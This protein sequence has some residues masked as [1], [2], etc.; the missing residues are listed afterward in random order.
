MRA[1]SIRTKLILAVA[2][3]VVLVMTIMIAYSGARF[4]RALLTSAKEYAIADAKAT[5]ARMD[6]VLVSGMQIARDLAGV[7]KG[8]RDFPAGSRRAILSGFARSATDSNKSIL[9]AWYIFEPNAVDGQDA[10]WAGKPGHTTKGQFVPYWFRNVGK[11]ELDFATEDVEGTVTSFYTVPHDTRKEYMTD[12]YQFDLATG[13]KVTAISFCVPIIVNDELVGVA[14]VD[15]G[16]DE[17]RA[18][19]ASGSS[20]GYAFILANDGTFIA[21]PSFDMVGSTFAKSLPQ[22]DAKYGI[23]GKIRNGEATSYVDLAAATNKVSFVLFEPVPIGDGKKPWSFGR[24]ISWTELTAP[25]RSATMLLALGGGGATLA[26]L[27]ALAFLISIIFKPL[28]RLEL[29]LASIG[30]GDAD[31]SQR[32]EAHS[33]DELG[34]MASSFNTFA[35]KLGGII[36]TARGVADELGADGAELGKAMAK[37]E[38][39]LSRVRAAIVE[40]REKSAEEN[41]GATKAAEAVAAIAGR[42]EALAASIEAQ[43]SGVVQSSASVE[44]MV[45]NI[46]SVGASVDRIAAELE[47]LMSAAETGREKLAEVEMTIQD[48][49]RQSGTL[50]DT[51]EAIAAI[52]SQTNLLAMNAAIEAAHAGEAGKGFAV[53]ADEIRKLAES[54]ATQSQETGRELGAIKAAIDGVVGSSSEAAKSFS[55]TVSA[56]VRT[57]DLATEVRRAMAEQD[58]GSKQILQALGEINTATAAVKNSSTEMSS[59]GAE[60][61]AEMRSLEESS[62][63]VQV[64]M[65]EVET[66]A[67]AI[68][69]AAAQAIRT[70]ERT[71][72]GISLLR[73]ELGRFKIEDGT[74]GEASLI[75][76]A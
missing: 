55:E 10:A 46:K 71:E 40:A 2:I 56:I 69:E 17:L 41:V 26:L 22:M 44:E 61:L 62:K 73:T 50:A 66:E 19:A 51:N 23:T 39:S 11:L 37:T 4:T 48:I 67:A 31:L 21:H 53:V 34:R 49:A 43:S 30:S 52:A 24:A 5:A 36:D 32:I 47:L 38:S 9:A 42:L 76:E 68:G 75:E 74:D 14:G 45:S 35:D 70:A 1:L 58:E 18:F 60:A 20:V 3:P 7:A 33:G 6:S 25:S 13:S 16:L 72:D 15:F 59:T 27:I 28:L 65:D 57:N 8:Y 12:P 29:A 63:R 54:S 64:I